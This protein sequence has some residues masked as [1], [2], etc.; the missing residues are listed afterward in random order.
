MKIFDFLL[1]LGHTV[2]V[3]SLVRNTLQIGS[4]P[5]FLSQTVPIFHVSPAKIK[6]ALG[7]ILFGDSNI[8]LTDGKQNISVSVYNNSGKTFSGKV[9]ICVY[10]ETDGKR[11]LTAAYPWDVVLEKEQTTTVNQEIIL[12]QSVENTFVQVFAWDANMAPYAEV[13]EIR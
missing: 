1:Q 6:L 3:A 8:R 4:S 2:F 9:Y 7:E 12:L 10:R 13:Y 5:D 11:E